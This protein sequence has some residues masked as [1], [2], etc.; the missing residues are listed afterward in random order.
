MGN[1]V[2]LLKDGPIPAQNGVPQIVQLWIKIQKLTFVSTDDTEV[3]VFDATVNPPLAPVDLLTLTGNSMLLTLA[4][5]PAG[6]YEEAKMV[7]DT[8]PA[9]LYF[10]PGDGNGNPVLDANGNPVHIPLILKD[11][12][13]GT[14]D[15]ALEF[16]FDPPV[17]VEAN[18]TT[19][20][21]IDFVPVV[22]TDGQGNYFLDHEIQNVSGEIENETEMSQVEAEG[23]ITSLAADHSSFTL[24]TGNGDV[25]VIVTGTTMIERDDALLTKADLAEGQNVEVEGTLDV[26][27]TPPTLTADRIEIEEIE[28][29]TTTTSTT[30]TST[31]S[32]T[33][34]TT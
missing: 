26:S 13:D 16:E 19:T 7:I 27:T 14:S 8:N 20:A 17:V 12:N 24:Q 33:T 34:T 15:G 2:V 18:G 28:Q 6:T 32:S 3:T 25:T 21:V 22:T 31:S 10:V 29:E 5:V 30:T 9:N 23:T 4:P 11:E 1:T